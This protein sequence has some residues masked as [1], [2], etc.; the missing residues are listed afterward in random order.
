M[1]NLVWHTVTEQNKGVDNRLSA[2]LESMLER[3]VKKLVSSPQTAGQILAIFN[4]KLLFITA[5]VAPLKSELKQYANK[6][7]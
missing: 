4:S 6:W 3:F 7:P 1:A 2:N 5:A